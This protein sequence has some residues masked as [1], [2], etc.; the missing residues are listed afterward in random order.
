[1]A[2]VSFLILPRLKHAQASDRVLV[3]G[4]H[5]PLCTTV[6]PLPVLRLLGRQLLV[7]LD[8]HWSCPESWVILTLCKPYLLTRYV[9]YSWIFGFDAD[10]VLPEC[11]S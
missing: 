10:A 11:A 8:Q 7:R 3:N 4:D 1:M 9:N 2:K 5:G 6:F